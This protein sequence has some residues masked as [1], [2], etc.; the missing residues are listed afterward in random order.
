MS[1]DEKPKTNREIA[2]M[3]ELRFNL[4]DSMDLKTLSAK[5][6][7]EVE[8]KIILEVMM[9]MNLNRSQLARVLSIDSKTLRA[10]LKKLG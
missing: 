9:R 1:A 2:I 4:E 8:R 6:Q 10:K 3:V 5:A 7:E